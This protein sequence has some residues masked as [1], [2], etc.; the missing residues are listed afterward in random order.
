IK[1][2][3]WGAGLAAGLAWM[4]V[5]GSVAAAPP[6]YSW[7][8]VPWGGGG[9]VDGFVYHPKVKGI[10][11]ARTD[12]GGAF[13]FDYA[14][15]RWIPLLDHLSRADGDMNGILSIALDPNDAEKVYMA[16][17]LYLGQWAHNAAIL[18]S[19]DRGATWTKT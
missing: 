15:K 13:R 5:V 8:T 10:L 3:I 4:S 14:H 19:S 17:G 6:A 1:R 18:S 9:Y 16:C 11:Y 7:R 12:V 2:R